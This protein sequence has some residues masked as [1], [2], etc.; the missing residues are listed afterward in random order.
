MEAKTT[1]FDQPALGRHI[2][3]QSS[4]ECPL[5]QAQMKPAKRRISISQLPRLGSLKST[6]TLNLES[7]DPKLSKVAKKVAKKVTKHA[8]NGVKVSAKLIFIAPYLPVVLFLVLCDC[9]QDEVDEFSGKED[10]NSI[11]EWSTSTL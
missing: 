6:E 10:V 4:R 7:L 11:S 9:L 2:Y 8:W 3:A 1:S 5:H